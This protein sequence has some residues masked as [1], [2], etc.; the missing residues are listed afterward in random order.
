MFK[1]FIESTLTV[2]ALLHPDQNPSNDHLI[3]LGPNLSD[4][5]Y[6]I[7]RIL[8]QITFQCLKTL[9]TRIYFKL[10]ITLKHSWMGM[11]ETLKYSSTHT[12]VS[13]YKYLYICTS[14]H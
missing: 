7:I 10:R 1:M 11:K 13:K 8:H 2:L 12:Y 14:T 4:A 5:D 9:L 3:L 6:Y